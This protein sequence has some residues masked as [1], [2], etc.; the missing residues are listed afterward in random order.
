[1]TLLYMG[2]IIFYYLTVCLYEKNAAQTTAAMIAFAVQ[3]LYSAFVWGKRKRPAGRLQM[4]AY[5]WIFAFNIMALSIYL[6]TFVFRENNAW[7]FLIMLILM[8][9]IYSTPPREM[10][11]ALPTYVAVFLGLSYYNKS[12]HFFFIDMISSVC[13]LCIAAISYAT[14]MRY[15]IEAAESSWEL[16]RM[17]RLDPMTGILNKS[18]FITLCEQYLRQ[19][20]PQTSYALAVTDIDHFKDVNDL[21]GHLVGDEVLCEFAGVLNEYFADPSRGFAGRFG[22][23]EFVSLIKCVPN[24]ESVHDVL[25]RLTEQF[26]STMLEKYGLN[27]TCSTGVVMESHSGITFSH[28]FLMADREL[29]AAKSSGGNTLRGAHGDEYWENKPLLLAVDLPSDVHDIVMSTFRKQYWI[30]ETE[31]APDTLHTLE[32]YESEIAAVIIHINKENASGAGALPTI[33]RLS[34]SHSY[35]IILIC[36]DITPH[37]AWQ[38]LSPVVLK[39]PISKDRLRSVLPETGAAEGT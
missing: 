39:P 7:L 29:Y 2:G 11:V 37:P 3:A 14:M 15:K 21:H 24:G 26:R 6:G 33:R 23:D 36:T 22:G 35:P 4:S 19:C 1:M 9:Q 10:M 25:L 34:P 32:R 17:C 31:G 28:L 16:S 5:L 12:T 8:T 18:A 13:A 30:L 27:V 38:A 20:P